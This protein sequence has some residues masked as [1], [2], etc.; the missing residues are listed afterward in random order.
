[1]TTAAKSRLD[2]LPRAIYQIE[3][4]TETDPVLNG[5]RITW[6]EAGKIK[7]WW[8][9]KVKDNKVVSMQK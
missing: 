1:M 8:I 2:K 5:T 4:D 6:E 9:I 7:G 3:I